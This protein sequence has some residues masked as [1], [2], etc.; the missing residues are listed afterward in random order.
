MSKWAV[1]VVHGVG[2]TGPGVTVDTFLWS[3]AAGNGNLQPDGRREVLWL[4]EPVAGS[5]AAAGQPPVLF[6]VHVRRARVAGLPPAAAPPTEVVAA[7]PTQVIAAPPTEVIVAPPTEVVAAP[8]TEMAAAP[9]AEAVPAPPMEA[10]APPPKAE[11]PA[12]PQRTAPPAPPDKAVFAE[13]YWADLSRVREGTLDLLYNL[14]AAIFFLR[15]IPA[16][17]SYLNGRWA[18]WVRLLLHLASW[19]LC[20]PIAALNALLA[21]TIGAYYW[22]VVPVQAW[23]AS[24]RVQLAYPGAPAGPAG[25]AA[26][27]LAGLSAAVG[28]VGLL[29]RRWCR[30]NN[31]GTTWT[32]FWDAF[33]ALAAALTLAILLL[34]P[35]A[36]E[37]LLW[38]ARDWLGFTGHELPAQARYPAA[39]FFGLLLVTQAAFA[40]LNTYLLCVTLPVWLVAWATRSGGERSRPALAIALGATLTQVA[41]WVLVLPP[42]AV[43]A[44][45]TLL[46]ETWRQQNMEEHFFISVQK[47]F[48]LHLVLVFLLMLLGLA[49]WEERRRWVRGNPPPFAYPGGHTSIPRLVVHFLI[50]TFL[51]LLAFSGTGLFLLEFTLGGAIFEF[52][53]I[54]YRLMTAIIS[55]VIAFSGLLLKQRLRDWLHI[56]SDI[57]NHFYQRWEQVPRPWE[58]FRAVNVRTFETQQLIEHRFRKTLLTLLDEPGVTHL[59]V[60]AHSQGTVVAVDVLSLGALDA[61]QRQ[62]LQQRLGQLRQ[63]D[64]VTMGSPFTHL[65]QHYFPER[66]PPLSHAS[67]DG[68][69]QC[70]RRW[71]NVYRVDDFIGTFIEGSG[72]TTWPGEPQNFP[73]PAGG[74]TGY[75]RQPEVLALLREQN[76]LPG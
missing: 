10:A 45:R 8:P 58:P 76:T 54:H 34:P 26:A 29:A 61:K 62:D 70:V 7:P 52:G 66:Y 4:E 39:I 6:P 23:A 28:V 11:A 60:V 50:V 75:W 47:S 16:W 20:G 33:T 42:V 15:F 49:V 3:L 67:W 72:S 13:V 55:L 74:H 64:L 25:V 30:R 17:A 31:S 12:P 73:L 44:T 27:T 59:T 18:R 38:D 46:P 48:A 63:L 32:R 9:P 21:W 57:I 1:L 22:I 68:L 14:A 37:Q 35:R 36:W 43:L 41:L 56:L 5:A 51:L 19:W 65:Y 53:S 71:L 40:V 2:D 69:R 24:A